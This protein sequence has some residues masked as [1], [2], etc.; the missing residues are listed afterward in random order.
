M[1]LE[2]EGKKEVIF[3]DHS[4]TLTQQKL[5]KYDFLGWAGLLQLFFASKVQSNEGKWVGQ[6]GL[7]SIEVKLRKY[8]LIL[9]F[10]DTFERW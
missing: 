2:S 10:E 4:T 7:V 1:L 9:T 8:N 3:F 5:R 6:W